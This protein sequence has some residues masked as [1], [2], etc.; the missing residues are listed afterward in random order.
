MAL[1]DGPTPHVD[2][3]EAINL[4][5]AALNSETEE[6][7]TYTMLTLDAPITL[8]PT[9]T[10]VAAAKANTTGQQ[11]DRVIG[12]CL[13]VSN[14]TRDLI[15]Q[16]GGFNPVSDTKIYLGNHEDPKL[17]NYKIAGKILSLSNPLNGTLVVRDESGTY[18]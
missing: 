7:G 15:E 4:F 6:E 12:A 5:N 9:T 10:I 2:F 1:L 11:F 17:G 14:N 13:V 16:G 8:N 18:N 3:V